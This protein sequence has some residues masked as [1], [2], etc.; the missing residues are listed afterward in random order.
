MEKEKDGVLS[1]TSFCL[2]DDRPRTVP[3][4]RHVQSS[5][6]PVNAHVPAAAPISASGNTMNHFLLFHPRHTHTRK[7]LGDCSIRV[8]W[9]SEHVTEKRE[10]SRCKEEVEG[11]SAHVKHRS[12]IDFEFLLF[13]YRHSNTWRQLSVTGW[14]SVYTYKERRNQH[15]SFTGF[16]GSTHGDVWRKMTENIIHILPF[17]WESN[18]HVSAT[19][20]AGC[21][22]PRLFLR[23]WL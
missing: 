10:L 8:C 11:L 20:I 7:T 2:C 13:N 4:H 21:F 17:Y 6:F 16:Y 15:S 12:L 22:Y 23:G 9:R 19:G 18:W 14:G 5:Q 1:S 3:L